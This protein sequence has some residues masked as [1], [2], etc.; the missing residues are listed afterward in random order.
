M[1]LLERGT[2]AILQVR[3]RVWAETFMEV[4]LN[5]PL[6]YRPSIVHDHVFPSDDKGLAEGSL[7]IID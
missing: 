1:G 6:P 3:S 5:E 7:C 2:T 4:G